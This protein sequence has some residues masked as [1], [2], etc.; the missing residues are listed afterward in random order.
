[1][2]IPIADRATLL[3]HLTAHIAT[4]AIET[5]ETRHGVTTFGP[6]QTATADPQVRYAHFDAWHNRT[7]FASAADLAAHCLTVYDP[8]TIHCLTRRIAAI[9]HWTPPHR[10]E[11]APCSAYRPAIPSAARTNSP[12]G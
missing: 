4:G 5:I 8:A 6:Y 10:E 7:L 3:H 9:G 2:T 12:R 11:H 1:M